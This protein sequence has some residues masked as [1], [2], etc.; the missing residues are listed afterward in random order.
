MP[1]NVLVLTMLLTSCGGRSDHAR[2][3]RVLLAAGSPGVTV[4]PEP[5]ALELED[6]RVAISTMGLHAVV[7]HDFTTG[8][9]DTVG[10]SGGGP[11][12]FARPA[13][14]TPWTSG[15][16]AVIDPV[17]RRATIVQLTGTVDTVVGFPISVASDNAVPSVDHTW[18]SL[19]TA[20]VHDSLPLIRSQQLNARTD[21][22]AWLAAPPPHII[23][24]GAVAMNMPLEYA[25]ADAYGRLPDGRVWIARGADNR[26]D[27]IA[28]SGTLTRGTPRPF[29]RIATVPADRHKHQGMPAP[30]ILD[31]VEREMSSVKAPFQEVRAGPDGDLWF[32]RNQPAGYATERYTVLLGDGATEIEVQLPGSHKVL[33]VGR[34]HVYVLG[35]N[36]DD[37][38]V[39]T[40]HPKPR[41]VLAPSAVL[42]LQ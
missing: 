20:R 40:R 33:A 38:P 29:A 6:G 30:P 24:L 3:A 27:W 13:S 42:K 14:M 8:R 18:L 26:V 39:I 19:G 21:T 9:A 16:F 10:R 1:R 5:Y 36:A 17:Q 28:P 34:K 31:T 22:L 25:A 15:R 12:E 11:G 35:T 7:V 37:E 32:W 41:E 2:D 23:P 4:G